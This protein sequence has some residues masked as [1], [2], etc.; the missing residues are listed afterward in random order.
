MLNSAQVQPRLRLAPGPRHTMTPQAG[1][2]SRQDTFIE[3]GALFTGWAPRGSAGSTSAAWS[4]SRTPTPAPATRTSTPTS[5]SRTRSRPCPPQYWEVAGDRRPAALQAKDP[6][7][8]LPVA[9]AAHRT[10]RPVPCL[11]AS[12]AGPQYR[13]LDLEGR[14]LRQLIEELDE[15][16]DGEYRNVLRHELRQLLR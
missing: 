9:R 7:H 11:P 1:P 10:R 3:I 5:R 16:R 13:L 8:Y 14:S 15:S 6:R 12:T 2:G 4:R